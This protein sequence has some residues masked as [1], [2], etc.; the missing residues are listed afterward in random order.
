MSCQQ[1]MTGASSA[2]NQDTW[3]GIAHTYA[4]SSVISMATSQ[5][6]AQTRY[7]HQV[8]LLGTEDEHQA[9]TTRTDH[10]LGI[11]I[12]MDTDTTPHP[13]THT[14]IQDIMITETDTGI[15]SQ[16]L[17]PAITATEAAADTIPA[18]DLLDHTADPHRHSTSCH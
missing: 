17:I 11:I 2:K 13:G 9:A 5:L 18:G 14:K 15:V 12:G 3:H 6:T 1:T 16:D 7:P 8:P 4:V 10:I